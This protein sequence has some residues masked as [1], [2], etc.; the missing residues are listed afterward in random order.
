[1]EKR[2][3]QFIVETINIVRDRFDGIP[4]YEGFAKDVKQI[5]D[6]RFG[7]EWNVLV[8]KSMGYA[9]K[10]KK[11]A[12]L[13]AATNEGYTVVCWKS[14][15]FEVEDSNIVRIRATIALATTDPLFIVDTSTQQ[16]RLNVIAT[17]GDR[18]EQ[19]MK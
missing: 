6:S 8:G 15:G 14:P 5:L 19:S 4:P 3:A 11:K 2:A 9:M 13:V 1:M 10:T 17:S 18:S 7:T 16:S 12:S